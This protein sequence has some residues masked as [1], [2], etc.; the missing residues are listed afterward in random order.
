MTFHF[1]PLQNFITSAAAKGRHSSKESR[2]FWTFQ[3]SSIRFSTKK[4]WDVRLP[5]AKDGVR[6][7]T[8]GSKV[9]Q[10]IGAGKL[11][12]EFPDGH[13]NIEGDGLT[14]LRNANQWGRKIPTI[15]AL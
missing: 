10:G 8:D 5:T 12:T 6:N 13:S 3:E 1:N 14:R 15:I 9:G 7:Y 2:L 4:E 11:T